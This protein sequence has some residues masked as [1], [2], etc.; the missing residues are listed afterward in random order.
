[1]I[2]EIKKILEKHFE[3]A[4]YCNNLNRG[5]ALK[6]IE[7]LFEERNI[8]TIQRVGVSEMENASEE[9]DFSFCGLGI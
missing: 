9:N 4:I 3:N 8:S 1:M 7:K 2:N 6:D 5:N